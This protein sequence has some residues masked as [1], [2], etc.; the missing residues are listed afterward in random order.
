MG[1]KAHPIASSSPDS[2]ARS[3]SFQNGA[4]HVILLTAVL[5]ARM[6]QEIRNPSVSCTFA[7]KVM[8]IWSVLMITNCEGFYCQ[9]NTLG[10]DPVKLAKKAKFR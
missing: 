9:G 1:Y 3:G 5:D 8:A 10:M 2:P 6:S 4:Y 7:K